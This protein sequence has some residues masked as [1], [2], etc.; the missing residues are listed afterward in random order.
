MAKPAP[1]AKTL[2]VTDFT[3]HPKVVACIKEVK[4]REKTRPLIVSDI[5]DAN[6]NQYVDLVQKGGGVLG[7]ALVGYTYV[8]EQMG[9]RFM[10]LAGTSAGAINTSLMTVIG[11]KEDTKSEAIITELCS[12]NFFDLVDGH[13][14][15]RWVIKRFVSEPD[16]FAHLK[17]WILM[18]IGVLA[19]LLVGDFIFLGLQHKST[20]AS[21]VGRILFVVTGIY[22]LGVGLGVVYLTSLIKRLKNS[23]FGINPGDF[24]YDWIKQKLAAHGVTSV[25]TL[26]AKAGAAIPGLQLRPGVHNDAG[27]GNLKGDVTFITSELV[28]KNKFQLPAMCNLFRSTEA[29]IDALQP[30]GFVRASMAIPVFFESYFIKDIPCDEPAVKKLW[31][32]MLDE[33]DPPSTV[34]FVDGGILSNFPINLFY[35]KEIKVPRLPTFGIDLDDSIPDDTTKHAES[36]SLGGYIGRMF[37]T[38]RYYYDKDFLLKNK[39]LE[40][41][42]GKV[43]LSEYNWLNFFLTDKEKIA[44]FVTGAEAARDFLTRFDWE[45]YKGERRELREKLKDTTSPNVYNHP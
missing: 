16:F 11:K 41:G 27:T 31:L 21:Y 25:G 32:D 17:K 5:L 23:G 40:L 6:G 35:N 39:V 14:A 10:R 15:A 24:F 26:N 33:D 8:L 28:T 34:R 30:A 9:I 36:W 22:H 12:L 18:A 45:E 3:S 7:I 42:I 38:I 13:R 44:M 29:E 19:L 20:W 43:P 1:T 4:D 37:N 2:S